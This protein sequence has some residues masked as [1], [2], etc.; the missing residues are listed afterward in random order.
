MTKTEY[1]CNN[2]ETKLQKL[3]DLLI[4]SDGELTAKTEQNF[5]EAV[6][7]YAE[8]LKTLKVVEEFES[9]ANNDR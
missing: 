6:K 4:N 9:G 5:S 8:A 3:T 2:I 1:I 7:N